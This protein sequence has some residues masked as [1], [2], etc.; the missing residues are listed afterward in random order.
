MQCST[1]G[2]PLPAGTG[3]PFCP[4][5]GNP[6]NP[7]NPT[8]SI[9]PQQEA[10]S[11]NN[12]AIPSMD[13]G[14]LQETS[15]VSSQAEPASPPVQPYQPQYPQYPQPSQQMYQTQPQRPQPIQQQH[16]IS[17]AGI[18]TGECSD[19]DRCTTSATTIPA[20]SATSTTTIYGLRAS[21]RLSSSRSAS[22]TTWDVRTWTVI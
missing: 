8:S 19:S 2:T 12:N 9:T 16:M 10:Y 11:L 17:W 5:C 22:A 18:A 3:S 1:C 6:I 7:A 4:N 15:S 14:P 21:T 13:F 20:T